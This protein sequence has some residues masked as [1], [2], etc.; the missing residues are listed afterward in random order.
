[1]SRVHVRSAA[2]RIGAG[3]GLGVIGLLSLGLAAATGLLTLPIAILLV[4][5]L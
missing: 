5:H 1:M 4:Q 3:I 2:A